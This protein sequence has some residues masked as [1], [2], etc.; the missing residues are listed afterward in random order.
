MSVLL[1]GR[2]ATRPIQ[3][4]PS[5]RFPSSLTALRNTASTANPPPARRALGTFA[6]VSLLSAFSLGA[7]T[8]GAI[9]PP[10][11][12]SLLYPRPAP[13]A[14]ADP[15]SP[16]SLEHTAALE[17]TL[18]SLP[19]LTAL[20]TAPDAADWYETRPHAALPDSARTHKL[21]IG[22]LRGPG[23]LA[24][25]PLARVRKDE[26]AAVVFVHLGRGLCGHDGIVHGGLLAT[27]LDEALGRNAI[28]NFP[29][30]VG[31]TA[32]LSLKYKAPTRADQFVVMK[33]HL[34]S[35][36]G[37]KARVAGRVETLD[38][39][40]LVEAEAL[41]IQPRYSKLLNTAAIRQ[42]IGGPPPPEP[43]LVEG[44]ADTVVPK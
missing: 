11:P 42:Q 5:L 1:L 38:G 18:Q 14:P 10:P 15:T 35:V 43:V 32:T 30:K 40:L 3:S 31:V 23:R 33:T 13:P 7:Y 25:F 27:L 44:G 19:A 24:L 16:A 6:T 36:D 41:F 8:L 39:T 12:L 4:I 34:V 28:T 9:Y 37:R 26:S 29:E 2:R 17:A 21:T 20:R 22:A